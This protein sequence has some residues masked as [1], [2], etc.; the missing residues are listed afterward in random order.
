M[1]VTGAGPEPARR[2][3]TTPMGEALI[4]ALDVISLGH[5]TAG[6]GHL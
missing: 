5:T 3:A 1:R 6:A 4:P 2:A